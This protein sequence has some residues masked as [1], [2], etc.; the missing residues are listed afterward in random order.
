[1]K[2]IISATLFIFIACFSGV[3]SAGPRINKNNVLTSSHVSVEGV[4]VALVPPKGAAVSKAFHG[5][6]D[7]DRGIRIQVNE[8]NGVSDKEAA[9]ALT[10]EGVAALGIKMT[11]KSDA[12]INSLPAALVTG[13]LASNGETGVMLLLT[14]SDRL[15][16]YIYG[17]YPI[18]DKGSETLVKNSLLS[19]IF[20]QE[21]VKKVSGGYTLSTEGAR[22]RFADEVGSTRYFTVDGKSTSEPVDTAIYTC[23]VANEVVKQEARNAYA[24]SSIEKY[25]SAYPYSVT[26]RRNVRYGGL[27]GIETTAEFKG[28]RDSVGTGRTFSGARRIRQATGKGYQVILFD[29][30]AGRVFIFSGITIRDADS[31]M[32]QFSRITSTFAL[33]R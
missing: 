5:F 3:S 30:D 11:D 2:K 16:V 14:G 7:T 28:E 4:H 17:M 32:R 19:C 13:T 10:P 25:L 31:F 24:D 21:S 9:G 6:E 33:K 20:N 23:T 18:G 1:M 22:L 15:S 27:N 26:G 12:V 29:E 8:T